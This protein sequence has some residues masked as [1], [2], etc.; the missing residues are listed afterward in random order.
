LVDAEKPFMGFSQR[1]LINEKRQRHA[2][3]KTRIIAK[4]WKNHAIDAM[5]I[6]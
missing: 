6:V 3:S 2:A 5:N 4:S 1:R